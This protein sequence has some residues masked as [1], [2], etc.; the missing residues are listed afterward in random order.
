MAMFLWNPV[1]R[2]ALS[3]QQLVACTLSLS[4]RHFSVL[5]RPQPNYP[6]H[7]PLTKLERLGLAVGSATV[8]LFNPRRGG[9]SQRGQ[10]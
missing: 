9:K 5:N 4:T 6:G 3:K 10:R 1:L 8:S 7:V 2:A